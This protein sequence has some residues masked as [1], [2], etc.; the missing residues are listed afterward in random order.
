MEFVSL[1]DGSLCRGLRTTGRTALPW[2]ARNAAVLSLA[3]CG[4]RACPR[5]AAEEAHGSRIRTKAGLRLHVL[6][7]VVRCRLPRA[8]CTEKTCTADIQ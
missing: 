6:R 7:F 3:R 2:S 4:L 8:N 1:S 5:V